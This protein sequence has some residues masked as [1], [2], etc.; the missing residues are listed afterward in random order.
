M[1]NGR[2]VNF[3]GAAMP[4]RLSW[5][6][7]F[8]LAVPAAVALVLTAGLGFD[9]LYGQDAYGYV[10]QA[11]GNAA[12]G[13][14]HPGFPGGYPAAM[15][16]LG[17]LTG[18]LALAG[19]LLSL[20]SFIGIAWLLHFVLSLAHPALERGS[21]TAYVLLGITFSPFL[22]RSSQVVMSDTWCAVLLMAGFVGVLHVQEE[23]R[24]RWV[25]W[26]VL[27]LAGACWVRF[28]AAP[29]A[30]V[31]SVAM[32]RAC[33]RGSRVGALWPLA[34]AVS[35]LV[36]LVISDPSAAGLQHPWLRDW[37]PL[38]AFRRNFDTADG[39]AHYTLPNVL[40]V[41]K[42]V[43]HPGF[44]TLGPLLLLFFRWRD[45]KVPAAGLALACL[46]AYVV[47]LM[48][49]PYQNER[50][51]LLAVPF[52]AVAL[53]PAYLRF[54]TA[55]EARGRDPVLLLSAV[56]A[57][58]L[59]LFVPAMN[60]LVKHNRVE[61]R[62]AQSVN[63]R[64]EQVLYCFSVSEALRIRC[65]ERRVIELWGAPV[66]RFE[67]GALVIFNPRAFAAQWSGMDPMLNWQRVLDQGAT[68]V[69]EWPDGWIVAR[70]P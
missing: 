67:P 27:F 10:H 34:I 65:P 49:P 16:A 51:L 29:V 35:A 44:F 48:G 5:F 25:A 46:L 40:H 61:R 26:T 31:L 15:A 6:H 58:Q 23:A 62:L 37:S 7:L 41:C 20:V 56:A 22:L 39:H 69:Q 36:L 2:I 54:R 3:A 21:I 17:H 9:G 14:P 59:A 60:G 8:T 50:F 38:N 12:V 30:I 13:S 68:P 1:W 64:P 28:A 63:D 45:R 4:V 70:V 33:V 19:R 53:F 52:V 55:L 57:L 18:D 66:D 32:V 42:V 24:S 11:A 43:V 47:F